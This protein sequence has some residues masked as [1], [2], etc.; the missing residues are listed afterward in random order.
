MDYPFDKSGLNATRKPLISSKVSSRTQEE[1]SQYF[2]IN[3]NDLNSMLSTRLNIA[4]NYKEG[5]QTNKNPKIPIMKKAQNDMSLTPTK[6]LIKH[7]NI[8]QTKTNN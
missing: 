3:K 5:F 7:E 6:T 1:N 2:F 4:K 8:V